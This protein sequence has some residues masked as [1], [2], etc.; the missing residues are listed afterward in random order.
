MGFRI[1]AI[2]VEP[3][4]CLWLK[5]ATCHICGITMVLFDYSVF[6]YIS[7]EKL[8]IKLNYT[9]HPLSWPKIHFNILT[10]TFFHSIR[11]V[12][13]IHILTWRLGKQIRT[14]NWS[15]NSENLASGGPIPAK[16]TLALH[17]SS[18][19]RLGSAI[20]ITYSW[21]DNFLSYKG[22]HHLRILHHLVYLQQNC[23]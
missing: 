14:V 2:F 6:S 1:H 21:K 15:Q 7:F 17:S 20:L 9:L 23:Q 13:F 11:G 22:L 19:S 3:P 16:F 10:L 4:W 8:I 12:Y 5:W 18:Q